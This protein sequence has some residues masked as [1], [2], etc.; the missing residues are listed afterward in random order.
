MP[1]G[2][3]L[4]GLVGRTPGVRHGRADRGMVRLSVRHAGRMS[5]RLRGQFPDL[6]DALEALSDDD[7]AAL[8]ER[9]ASDA[10]STVR[11]VVPQGSLAELDR[12]AAE[13]DDAG[14]TADSAGEAT[15]D[16]AA[17][18]RARAA[19]AVRDA[20]AVRERPEAAADSLYESVMAIGL[21]AVQAH[22]S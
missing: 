6:A 19:F 4:C 22:L 8:V 7:E 20:R 11:V 16:Q 14:W 9:V 2:C 18:C 1:S 3:A 17:F 5:A 13:L 10:A 15:Q 12:W 21:T